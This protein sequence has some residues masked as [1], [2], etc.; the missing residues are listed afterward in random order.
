MELHE[1]HVDQVGSGV[2]RERM[3]VAGVLPAVARDLVR[4]ADAAGREHNGLRPEQLE[5]APFALVR[6]SAHDAAAV[7]EQREHGAL[8][9]HVDALMDAV[10]L[11]GP[12]HLEARPIANVGEPR[13]FMPAEISLEDA[14]V[15]RPVEQRTPCLELADRLRRFPGM[16]LGHA[17]VVEVLAASHRIGKM[18]GPAVAIVHIRQRGRDSSFRHD[19]VGLA[20]ERF[21][22]DA[23]RDA[24]RRSLDR[25][26]QARAASADHQDIVFVCCVIHETSGAGLSDQMIR[27]SDQIPMEHS[28]T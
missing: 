8:H 2:I 9:V 25:R 15:L 1:L 12:D 23:D 5:P 3:P 26:A 7:G 19:G 27:R 11:Q 14:A 13:I 22:D 17:P 24:L 21:A 4:A 6:E 28:L 18:D 20:E 16:E 10:I